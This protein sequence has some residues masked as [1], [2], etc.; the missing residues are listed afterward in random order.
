MLRHMLVNQN[1]SLENNKLSENESDLID[2][3][4]TKEASDRDGI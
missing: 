3:K 2:I 4:L 1:Y